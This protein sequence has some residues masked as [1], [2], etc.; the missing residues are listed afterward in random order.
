MD[1]VM[2]TEANLYRCQ[3]WWRLDQP[4]K[5]L[6]PKCIYS[7]HQSCWPETPQHAVAQNPLAALGQRNP[8]HNIHSKFPLAIQPSK[9]LCG[10]TQVTGWVTLYAV[11]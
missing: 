10:T 11:C 3:T 9:M 4:P 6:S 1:R 5:V 7:L 8:A 2:Q